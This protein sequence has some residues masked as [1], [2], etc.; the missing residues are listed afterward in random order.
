[1]Y[2]FTYRYMRARAHLNMHSSTHLCTRAHN[3]RERVN[4]SFLLGLL[5]EAKGKKTANCNKRLASPDDFTVPGPSDQHYLCASR[6]HQQGG[7]QQGHGGRSA[8]PRAPKARWW[9][10]HTYVYSDVNPWTS[11]RLLEKNSSSFEGK[12]HGE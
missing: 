8:S 1:M 10:E 2:I 6:H 7:L 11:G 3:Y 12:V 5:K 9:S 4:V